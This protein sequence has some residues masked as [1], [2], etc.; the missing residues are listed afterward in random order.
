MD[1]SGSIRH[2]PRYSD[3][4]HTHWLMDRPGDMDQRS[5]DGLEGWRLVEVILSGGAPW[6]FTLKGGQEHREP[7][8]ITKVEESSKAA[9][10]GLQ[11]GDEMV[12]INQVPLTGYRQEAIC[13]VK[14]TH[15]TLTLVVKRRI[16]PATRP[17]SWHATKF[18]EIQ[19]ET[20]KT[21]SSLRH[22]ASSSSTDLSGGWDQ[23]HLHRGSDQF[24][25][26]GSMESFD[27]G[28]EQVSVSQQPFACPSPAKSHTSTEHL[29][30]GKRDSAY[31][32]FSTS[33]V[34]GM[35]LGALV[36]TDT[37]LRVLVRM[38]GQRISSRPGD[39]VQGRP[40]DR[41]QGRPGDRVQ[42][43]PGDRVQG[44]PGDRVQGEA[45]SGTDK[46]P[47]SRHSYSSGPV[48]HVP[49]KK[50]TSASS[51]SPLPPV[52]DFA[53]AK[54]HEKGLV[55]SYAE[56]VEAHTPLEPHATG[57][58]K[59]MDSENNHAGCGHHLVT[60]KSAMVPSSISPE[61]S[62]HNQRYTLSSGDVKPGPK[63]HHHRHHSGESP[64]YS[65]PRPSAPPNTSCYY[66]SMQELPT[67]YNN[68][69]V[70]L[71]S[72][73][74]Q[75][76]TRPPS[77]SLLSTSIN[78]MGETPGVSQCRS[79][80][81]S[82]C[83]RPGVD[84]KSLSPQGSG[85]T[86]YQPLVHPNNPPPYPNHKDWNGYPQQNNPRW[87][88]AVTVTAAAVPDLSTAPS[89]GQTG[90]GRANSQ[91]LEPYYMSYTSSRPVDQQDTSN[92]T[93]LCP[94]SPKTTPMLHSLSQ[95]APR[96]EAS[97]GTSKGCGQQA[98]D[99]TSKGCGQQAT[100]PF[101]SNQYKRSE[102]FATTLRNE[103][104]MR[105]AKL[106]NSHSSADLS[107]KA[108]EDEAPVV[109]PSNSPLSDGSS[110]SY[111]EHLKEA[112][113]RVLKATSFR[114]KDLELIVL[115]Q[116]RP[117]AES[118]YSYPSSGVGN[119]DICH[120]PSLSEDRPGKSCSVQG[121][122]NRIGGRK[123]FTTEKKVRSF[124][125]P[126]KMNKVLVEQQRL[127]TFAEYE[128]TW[129]IQKKPVE[130]KPSGRY[131]SADN[132]LDPVG[133]DQSK[134]VL[135]HERSRS[136]P[137]ADFYGKTQN[138]LAPGRKSAEYCQPESKPVE[139]KNP[140]TRHC[141]WKT[142]EKTEEIEDFPEPP[143]PVTDEDS[144]S[145]I[146]PDQPYSVYL[147]SPTEPNC[148]PKRKALVQPENRHS[149]EPLPEGGASTH[150]ALIIEYSPIIS[151]DIISSDNP[152]TDSDQSRGLLEQEVGDQSVTSNPGPARHSLTCV[153]SPS[154]EVHRSPSPQFA[155]QFTP[156]RLTDRPPVSVLLQH[157]V[158]NSRVDAVRKVPIK[159]VHSESETE[160][161]SRQYLLQRSD[162]VVVGPQGSGPQGPGPTPP[163]SLGTSGEPDQSYSLFC[164][165]SRQ[166][167]PVSVLP[168]PP[169]SQ[170]TTPLPDCTSQQLAP[171]PDR[172][173]Q[174]EAPPPNPPGRNRLSS[175]SP[176]VRFEEDVKRKELARDIINKDC[177][178]ADIL[179]QSGRRTTMDL[180]EGLFPQGEVLL[181]GK[182]RKKIAPKHTKSP[183]ASENRSDQSV[184]LVINSAY[185]ST[186]APKAELL[187]KLKDM[188]EREELEEEPESEEELDHDLAIKKQELV[189]SLSRK[190]QVLREARE[191]LHDDVQDNNTLGQEVEVT[192]QKLCKP[193]QLDKFRMFVGDLDK[194]VSLLLSLSGRLARVENA[195]NSLE[196]DAPSDERRNLAEKRKLLILQH[197]DAKELK[198]N[199]DRREK[200][201]YDILASYLRE[202]GLADYQH[203][204]KMK[205]AL[206][207][208]QRKLDDKIKLGEEQ[209]KC[210][211]DSLPLEQRINL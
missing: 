199:L 86:K 186:S 189:D 70:L 191:S 37:V 47:G 99:G 8:L 108:E 128:A 154:M 93:K 72:Q 22:D 133:R 141:E 179:D 101:S 161:E 51:P 203:F 198:E 102:R 2:G 202:E 187:I 119:K 131:H 38:R 80:A 36:T 62:S 158:S 69:N 23:T 150:P 185:Y 46:L 79:P 67:N 29:G 55:I 81:D 33:S 14:G 78:Q 42:G 63:P 18:N 165:Y 40:G 114:R 145:S 64:L 88:Q 166:R 125:E 152:I 176:V 157:P 151:S 129:N 41:V 205:S 73:P 184:A 173:S 170:Q 24:S 44:R 5:R 182:E 31:S 127:G 116:P 75:P 132:I 20:V 54:S 110:T 49:D 53:A 153:A 147:F 19:S 136:S 12:N 192:V 169:T 115:E 82:E 159:I 112:Q 206:I 35:H 10:A 109:T 39:R 103:I 34:S 45:N 74:I 171:P 89:D 211:M 196:D 208:E 98:R 117:E 148:G 178:L 200:V 28:L 190:L 13:L 43:R 1:T 121:Q 16:E 164:A 27:P 94:F 160:K 100:D 122:V 56:G 104:Q 126:N 11:A 57:L 91:I 60:S 210:L 58:G 9:A 7:L 66:S 107:G 135:V 30:G 183:R 95:E 59:A 96:F 180:M 52:H 15:R 4:D 177:S 134:P 149:Q 83:V 143:S 76:R 144:L 175:P 162:S 207:I 188:Q 174:K 68:Q 87:K 21:Q 50:K 193:N 84:W 6:G 97:D 146:P 197:E 26:L 140:A 90:W 139:Q 155:P 123:R 124:S 168:P 3:V 194:V 92:P 17:H 118:L 195:L 167:D 209:L 181:E 71:Y 138:N 113:A 106:Q 137:S 163:R 120:L 65:Q 130:T 201:V 61:G 172:S 142:R 48:W 204:V 25:S 111:I 105:R 85:L 32:S 77:T 156:Q